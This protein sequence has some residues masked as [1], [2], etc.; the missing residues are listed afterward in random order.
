M[1]GGLTSL[2]AGELYKFDM[3][4]SFTYELEGEVPTTI[5]PTSLRAGWNWIGY[6]GKGIQA[7]S[8]ALAGS[9]LDDG[10]MIVGQNGFSVYSATDGWVGTLSSLMPGAGYL[11]RSVTTKSV[12]F[13]AAKSSVLLSRSKVAKSA[14]QWALDKHAYPNVMGL[15]ADLCM[16]NLVLDVEH[17]TV[18]AYDVEGICRG[19]GEI[20]DSHIFM[21]LYG[22]GDELLTFKAVDDYG[23]TYSIKEKINFAADVLGTR[24]SPV[25]LTLGESNEIETEIAST[26]TSTAVPVGYY[27]LSGVFRGNTRSALSSGIYIV[28]LADGRCQ[29]IFIR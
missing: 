16:E 14:N 27:S 17:F 28:R 24:N 8:A 29:K 19:V 23:T 3:D 4:Q 22:Q 25:R 1:A 15:I 10:D 7:L 26:G 20:V 21:T 5:A 6:P 13:N 9:R 11:Y 18:I 2:K 12:R